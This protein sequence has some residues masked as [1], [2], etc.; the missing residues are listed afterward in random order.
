[1]TNLENIWI[2]LTMTAPIDFEQA[3]TVVGTLGPIGQSL[4][5]LQ[6]RNINSWRQQVTHLPNKLWQDNL[7]YREANSLHKA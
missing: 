7:K 6:V 4:Q 3:E 2:F 1:M 5:H